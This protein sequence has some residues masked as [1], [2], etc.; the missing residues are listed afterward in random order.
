MYDL[1]FHIDSFL[2][3]NNLRQIVTVPTRKEQTLDVIYV[4][5]Q[6]Q[7]DFVIESFAPLGR[8][9]HNVILTKPKQVSKINK[10][11]FIRDYSAQ[12]KCLFK[13]CLSDVVWCQLFQN[14]NSTNDLVEIFDQTLTKIFNYSF[15]LKS[16][17]LSNKDQPWITPRIKFLMQ[18]KDRALHRGTDD[19][20]IYQFG[21]VLRRKFNQVS[22]NIMRV[23]QMKSRRS[24]GQK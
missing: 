9:D 13:D 23:R 15:P 18:E 20:N 3:S 5:C 17:S 2:I 6:L 12:N 14:K 4:P 16:V 21:S 11:V 22:L 10:K 1:R 7:M 24:Y 8:S 19:T